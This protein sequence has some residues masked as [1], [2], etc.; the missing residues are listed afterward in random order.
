MVLRSGRPADLTLIC[1]PCPPLPSAPHC[2]RQIKPTVLI[3]VSTVAGAFSEDVLRAMAEL[4]P[5]PIIMPLSNPT[6]KSECTFEAAVAATRGRVLFASGSPFPPCSH[7]GRTLYPAQVGNTCGQGISFAAEAPALVCLRAPGPLPKIIPLLR[8]L[9]ANNAYIFPAVGHAAVLTR[10]KEIRQALGGTDAGS[11]QPAFRP[12]CSDSSARNS[13]PLH[14]LHSHVATLVRLRPHALSLPAS[15]RRSDDVFLAA[16]EALASMSS[17]AQLEQGHLFPAFAGIKAVSAHLIATV[18]DFMVRAP[19]ACRFYRVGKAREACRNVGAVHPALDTPGL[20]GRR[21]AASRRGCLAP[22]RAA[23]PCPLGPV[24]LPHQC[25]S[26]IPAPAL[27]VPLSMQV[28]AGLGSLPADFDEA[29]RRSGLPSS[30]SNLT[31][32]EAYAVAH[33]YDPNAAKL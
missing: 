14:S 4:N 26:N 30:A 3:G 9:Q 23:P 2:S 22:L 19:P 11:S 12:A 27:P 13:L 21:L 1:C 18:A 32:W 6:S 5:R 15:H 17:V 25:C 24:P 31:R 10:C 8:S 28:R 16:A 33:M 29:V 20:V 7:G